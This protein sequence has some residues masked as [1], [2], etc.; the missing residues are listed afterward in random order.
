MIM[1]YSNVFFDDATETSEELR[2]ERTQALIFNIERLLG[3]ETGS[4]T[5]DLMRVFS[6]RKVEQNEADN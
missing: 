4:L 2:D 6:S 1:V 5:S 3:A